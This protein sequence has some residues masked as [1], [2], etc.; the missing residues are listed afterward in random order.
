MFTHK[1]DYWL[2]KLANLNVSKSARLGIAPHKPL[3]IF[4]VMDLIEMGELQNSHVSYNVQLVTRFRDYWDH[5]VERRK[6]SPDI[7]MPFHAL[8]GE[9]DAVWVRFDENGNPS[10]SKL[11]TRCCRLDAGLYRCLLD[12]KF[13]Q[14]ARRI[15]IAAYFP[16]EEQVGLYERFRLPLPDTSEIKQFAKDQAAFKASQNKGRSIRFRAEIGAG[17]KYTCALTG[18]SLHTPDGYMIQAAHIHEHAK[19]GNDDPRNGLALSPDAH[20]M[21][22][23]GLW[24]AVPEK[25]MFVIKVALDR[26]KET[27]P[28]ENLLASYDGKPLFFHKNATLRPSPEHLKWHRKRHGL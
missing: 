1:S 13:R 6:N 15:M 10:K 18:Y 19:S 22:D 24:T 3:M 2:G 12:P 4:S 8:G 20:W 25:D 16:P 28:S 17:Y 5:V 26:F 27:S 14:D 11:T 7:Q 9:Q 23:K 21:F